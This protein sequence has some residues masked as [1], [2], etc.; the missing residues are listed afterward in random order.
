MYDQNI[1]WYWIE[2]GASKYTIDYM[3]HMHS[4]NSWVFWLFAADL[5]DNLEMSELSNTSIET[6]S[7]LCVFLATKEE[8]IG[9]SLQ[10]E[11]LVQKL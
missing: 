6:I 1:D 4:H 5:S 10:D 11:F 2:I 3:Q 7:Y 8:V 9:E